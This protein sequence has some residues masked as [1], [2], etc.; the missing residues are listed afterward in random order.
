MIMNFPASVL[1]TPALA[2]SYIETV[3]A[4]SARPPLFYY[5]TVL[6]FFLKGRE[7]ILGK[8]NNEKPL[9]IGV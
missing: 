6:C 4:I 2:V 7:Q 8:K 1:L 3:S 9:V 5:T